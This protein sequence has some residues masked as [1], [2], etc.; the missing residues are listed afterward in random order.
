MA[1]HKAIPTALEGRRLT[2]KGGVHP[3]EHK[4]IAEHLAIERAPL[5]PEVWLP[6]SMHAGAQAKPVVA[7][8]DEV[9]RGQLVAEA[10]GFVS[11][12]IHSPVCGTVKEIAARP[13]QSGRMVP[14]IVVATN[15]EATGEAL[16]AEAERQ[17]PAD[18]DLTSFSPAQIVE[19]VKTG[20][21]V[22]QGGAAFP[23]FIKPMVET[24]QLLH[25]SVNFFDPIRRLTRE[26][27]LLI[28]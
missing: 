21:L 19:R 18:L 17:V 8:P 24:R 22:G 15:S 4:N 7:K 28:S 16:T 11:A 5:P 20:G 1:S 13:H 23:T 10:G 6:V 12:P 25:P 2:F 9:R 3:V 14:T 27:G 26:F